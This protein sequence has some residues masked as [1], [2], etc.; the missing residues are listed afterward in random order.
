MPVETMLVV[1]GVVFLAAMLQGL[2]GFGFN[3]L[4]VPALILVFSPQVVVP[5]VILTYVPLGIA[6]VCLLRRDVDVRLWAA[7][8]CG[9]AIALPLGALI[10]RD[11]DALAMKRGIG[12]MM[13]GLALLLQVRPGMP[14]RR[15]RLWRFLGGIVSGVLASSTG[16]SGPPLVLLGL[17]QQWPYRTFRAT[18][19][20][21][22]LAVSLLSLPLHYRL[23]LVTHDTVQFALAGFPGL[24]AGFVAGNYLRRWVDGRRFRWLSLG[25][26]ICGG[27]AALVF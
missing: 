7:L 5:G 20:A 19:I 6:Q 3:M 2:S 10:L 8:V 24:A 21:Y 26:V 16:V 4:A 14:F 23:N 15:D 18:L 27:L 12:A 22:F 11:T 9:A 25:M 17:K 1:S 13:I